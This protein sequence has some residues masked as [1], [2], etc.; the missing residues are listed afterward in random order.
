MVLPII[1]VILLICL[2]NRGRLSMTTKPYKGRKN[3]DD[4]LFAQN[5]RRKS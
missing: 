4:V 1:V 2:K 3:D 5:D